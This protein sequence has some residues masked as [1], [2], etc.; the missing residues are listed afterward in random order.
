MTYKMV[1]SIGLEVLFIAPGDLCRIVES[2]SC[3]KMI[4]CDFSIVQPWKTPVQ[5]HGGVPI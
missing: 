4:M 5:L 1:S 2:M 3:Q